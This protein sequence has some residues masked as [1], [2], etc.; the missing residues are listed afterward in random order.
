MKTIN[1]ISELRTHIKQWRSDNQTIAFVPTMGNLHAGH[2]SLVE[3]ALEETDRVV[4]S[5][6]V[7]PL[8]FGQGEDYQSYPRTLKQDLEQL[9]HIGVLR[10]KEAHVLFTPTVKDIYPFGI[11]NTTQVHVPDELTNLLCGISR[12]GHFVGV[13]TVVNILFNL[14]QPDKALFGQKDYQQLL[15]I[16][17]MVKD[18]QMPIQII[19]GSIVREEDGLA[20]S[21]RN[22]Y[23]TVEERQLA[24]RLF[25][26]L[27]E[28]RKQIEGGEY[29]FIYLEDQAK[30]ELREY[31]FK[32]DY[33]SVRRAED[34]KAPQSRQDNEFVILAAAWLGKTRLIDNVT[35]QSV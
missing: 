25:K 18:L 12:P 8:Q 32:P 26:V 35:C 6:F 15:I 4:V 31:G 34:L 13:A 17:R 10:Q 23:L 33:V 27:E 2:L 29:D 28:V 21:S 1:H 3:R 20:M 5:I 22:A 11:Q 7:N 30:A 14:V 9:E 16:Q 24:P 19:S